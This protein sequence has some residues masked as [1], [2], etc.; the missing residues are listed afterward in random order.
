MKVVVCPVYFW[1]DSG[2]AKFG[3]YF[4]SRMN[5]FLES[6]IFGILGV[7]SFDSIEK[8]YDT[9]ISSETCSTTAKGLKFYVRSCA[10]S[11]IPAF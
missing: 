3:I 4:F 5:H 2:D 8:V 10:M 9:Y 7:F 6:E 1:L 11:A